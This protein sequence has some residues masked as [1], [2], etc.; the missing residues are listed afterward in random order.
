MEREAA[1]ADQ[2]FARAVKSLEQAT[3]EITFL[4][5]IEVRYTE[6]FVVG[7]EIYRRME[8][9]LDKVDFFLCMNWRIPKLERYHKTTVI[10]QNGNEGI[11]FAAYCNSIGVEAY[12][13]MDVRDLNE[14][15][16]GRA[17]DFRN[18]E[19]DPGSGD[20]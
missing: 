6:N 16:R 15:D 9:D 5:P 20:H 7:E 2:A 17:A 12:V 3:D 1:Y 14:I 8:E 18:P 19:P 11:D 13:A 10:L 4:E